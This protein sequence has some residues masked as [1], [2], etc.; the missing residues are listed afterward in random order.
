MTRSSFDLWWAQRCAERDGEQMTYG[1][2]ASVLGV[3]ESRVRQL[4]AR[5]LEKMRRGLAAM[6]VE[7]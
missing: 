7:P 1:E 6:G 3:D 5:A 4:E 2:I